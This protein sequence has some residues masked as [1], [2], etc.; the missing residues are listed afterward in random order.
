MASSFEPD[1]PRMAFDPHPTAAAVFHSLADA[2]RAATALKVYGIGST[3]KYPVSGPTL[4]VA[5]QDA[6]ATASVV[7]NLG[8]GFVVRR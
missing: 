2:Q 8:T 5:Q 6:E 3:I 1:A 7:M 4:Y